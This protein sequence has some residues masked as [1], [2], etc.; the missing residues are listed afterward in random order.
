MRHGASGWGL[1]KSTSGWWLA[2]SDAEHGQQGRPR[3]MEGVLGAYPLD[4][5]VPYVYNYARGAGRSSKVCRSVRDL[6]LHLCSFLPNSM[7]TNG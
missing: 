4:W 1:T 2:E 6:S 3:L 7:S 5:N